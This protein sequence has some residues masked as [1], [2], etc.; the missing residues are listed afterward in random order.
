MRTM[1]KQAPRYAAVILA[2]ILS[3]G[4]PFSRG[5]VPAAHANKLE[6]NGASCEALQKKIRGLMSSSERE[7]FVE[8]AALSVSIPFDDTCGLIHYDIITALIGRREFPPPYTEFILKIMRSIRN[9]SMDYRTSA[10]LHYISA[11]G[12]IDDREWQAGLDVLRESKAIS[13][14]V[15]LRYLFIENEREDAALIKKRISE[16]LELSEKKKIGYPAPIPPADVML[17]LIQGLDNEKYF[18]FWPTMFVIENYQR[19]LPD[20]DE[21][22]RLIMLKLTSSYRLLMENEVDYAMQDRIVKTIIQYLRSRKKSEAPARILL[23]HIVWLE[24]QVSHSDDTFYLNHLAA[25]N[26]ALSDWICFSRNSSR[27][28]NDIKKRMEY[29]K[30]NDIQCGENNKENE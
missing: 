17:G 26:E 13:L 2:F 16:V 1:M 30:R 23:N 24:Y 21:Y 22:N 19:L 5:P 10:C 3:A 28:M 4:M 18:Q 12:I 7:K 29:I 15:Y 8:G 25:F 9:A 27:F 20:K 6:N 14:P 11:D